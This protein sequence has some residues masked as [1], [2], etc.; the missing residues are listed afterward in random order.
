MFIPMFAAQMDDDSSVMILDE[1]LNEKLD[2]K[3]CPQPSACI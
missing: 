1:H 3:K 2:L